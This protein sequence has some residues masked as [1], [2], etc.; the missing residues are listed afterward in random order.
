M[1]S[2]ETKRLAELVVETEKL[3]AEHVNLLIEVKAALMYS[4]KID[5]LRSK[6]QTGQS[7]ED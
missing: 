2:N 1:E 6:V 5:S 3:T 7:H 4:H